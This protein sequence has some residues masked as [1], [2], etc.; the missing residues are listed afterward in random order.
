MSGKTGSEEKTLPPSAKKLREARRKGQVARSKEMVT[1]AV[2]LTA[3]GCLYAQS[4]ALIDALDGVLRAASTAAERPFAE[5]LPFMVQRLGGE[6]AWMLAPLAML[7]VAAAVVSNVAVNG[8]VLAAVDPLMPN[9]ERLNPVE[10][11][12]RLFALRNVIELLKSVLKVGLVGAVA[13]LLIR[14]SLQTLVEQPSCGLG[15][16]GPVLRGLLRPLLVVAGLFFVLLGALD[17]G[18]QRWLFL[19][20]MRMTKT[21]QKRERKEQEGDPLIK[22]QHRRDQRSAAQSAVRTGLR[23][24]TFVIRSADVALALRFAKPDATVPVLL[25]RATGD[26]APVLIEEARRLRLPIVFDVPAAT[27]VASRLKIGQVI[28]ADMFDVVI[29]CMREAG[30]L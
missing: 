17:I 14:A 27:V 8:G 25:A 16:A 29:A 28:A 26:A 18:T 7:I 9:M 12:A 30:V 22:G 6:L 2:T 4:G 19:R 20:D 13:V 11:F 23:N 15:C 24:A 3:F 10:G 21:E 5:V 1:A